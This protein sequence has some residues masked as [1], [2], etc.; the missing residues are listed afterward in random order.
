[1]EDCLFCKI[2]KKEIPSDIIYEDD[3]VLAFK[4]IHPVAPIHVLVIPKRHISMV[5]ELTEEDGELLG[6][7]YSA[8]NYVAEKEGIKEKGF[9]I[10][11]NCGEDGG[12]AIGHLHFHVLGGKKLGE[13]IVH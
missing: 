11:I 5:T 13:K 8:I 10:I 12:Q 1:M 9:R 7:I 3:D 4:D 2:V 6:K